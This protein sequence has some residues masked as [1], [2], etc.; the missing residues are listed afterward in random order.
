LLSGISAFAGSTGV[1]VH[2]IFKDD[3]ATNINQRIRELVFKLDYRD[4]FTVNEKMELLSFGWARDN[5]DYISAGWYQEADAIVYWPED[6]AILTYEGNKDYM[7][8]R[9]SMDQGRLRGEVLSVFHIGLNKKV[10]DELRIGA[11]AKLYNSMANFYSLDNTGQFVTTETPDGENF[12]RHDLIDADFVLHTSGVDGFSPVSMLLS[13][14]VGLGLDLGFTYNLDRQWKV[15]G[16]LLDIGFIMHTSDLKEHYLQGDYTT[17]GIE[18]IFPAV[19]TEDDNRPYW[20][21]FEQEFED[22]VK[23]GNR[24]GG[25]YLTLRPLKL[26]GSLDYAWGEPVDCHCLNPEEKTYRNHAGVMVSAI[27]RPLYPYVGATLY[28]EAKLAGF[29]RGKVTYTA[30]QYSLTNF[31]L[32]ASANIKG[33]NFYIAVDNILAAQNLAK[34]KT[35]GVQLGFQIVK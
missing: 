11:R 25:S 14:N 28:Y 4:N 15:T 24:P 8:R 18:L 20:V 34:A 22:Q 29:L 23:Y 10:S 21:D 16:S 33:F 12:Y 27:K 17:S 9:F 19:F 35:A 30:D 2:D 6:G 32:L 26:Y 1:T 31:G 3:A 7:G 5:G 13:G